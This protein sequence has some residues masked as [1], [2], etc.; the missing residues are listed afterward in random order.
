MTLID[1]SR[2][3]LL[4]HPPAPPPPRRL[5][6][7]LDG[8]RLSDVHWDALVELKEFLEPF[9]SI[10][11]AAEG[12]LYPTAASVVP[13]YNQLLDK[14][15]IS[16]RKEGVTPLRQALVSA[17]LAKLKKYKYGEKEELVI[18]TF[19]DPRY[20]TVFFQLP[21]WEARNAARV[22][23][24]GGCAR[25][26][27]DVDEGSVIRLV[28]VRLAEYQARVSSRRQ[29]GEGTSALGGGT[30]PSGVTGGTSGTTGA[31][32]GG[33]GGFEH[34]IFDEMDA[35]EAAAG[36]GGTGRAVCAAPSSN[37]RLVSR[38]YTKGFAPSA[39][40]L[41]PSAPVSF[42]HLPRAPRLAFARATHQLRAFGKDFGRAPHTRRAACAHASAARGGESA[43]G[44]HMPLSPIPVRVCRIWQALKSDWQV[45]EG[46]DGEGGKAFCR[47]VA[48]SAPKIRLMRSAD[49]SAGRT[50]QVLNL[51]AFPR[52]EYDLPYFCADLVT[53]PRGHLIVLDLNPLHQTEEH[54]SKYIA[55]IMP[56]ANKYI[57]H[58]PWGGEFTAESLQFFSPALLWAKLPLDADVTAHVLP[59][60]QEYLQAWLRMVEACE[61]T[62]DPAVM[63]HNM[64]SQH[65][66]ICWRSVKDPGRPLLTR[67]FGSERCE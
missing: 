45:L 55:P 17:A 25:R 22:T 46:S 23:E 48:V 7:Q 42:C 8:L 28:R 59:A 54:F 20:K 13:L 36:G 34:S 31:A 12:S 64:E 15:E 65:R 52:P 40:E 1:S 57:E 32:G 9:N 60:F 3:V 63:A 11:K 35:L 62:S 6:E 56:I 5:R 26:V 51:I 16:Y 41:A 61:P 43:E 37:V 18:A 10:T 47:S 67:L 33:G 58:L 27:Q 38:R 66:Y 14:L 53:F 19:L 49:I 44:Q 24:V 4:F 39:K 2:T 30:G 29:G 21:K 50:L